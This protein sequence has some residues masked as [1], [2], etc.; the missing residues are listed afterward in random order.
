MLKFMKWWSGDWQFS[1]TDRRG[2]WRGAYDSLIL[3][4]G[5]RRVRLETRRLSG[6][7]SSGFTFFRQWYIHP[8]LLLTEMP[9]IILLLYKEMIFKGLDDPSSPYHPSD[10]LTL[11]SS[12]EDRGRKRF[13][14]AKL[15]SYR[16]KGT[17]FIQQHASLM[18]TRVSSQSSRLTRNK[19]I[20]VD[21]PGETRPFNLLSL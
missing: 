20:V 21:Q 19:Q 3:V 2:C 6:L 13:V 9:V 8:C 7:L 17:T 16:R 14:Y 5:T 1:P 10:Q 4:V 15:V 12:V 11:V 18:G